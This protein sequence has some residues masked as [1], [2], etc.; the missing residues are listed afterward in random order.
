[1]K[2]LLIVLLLAIPSTVTAET[3]NLQYGDVH[4]NESTGVFA[5]KLD[6]DYSIIVT[7]DWDNQGMSAVIINNETG[8]THCIPRPCNYTN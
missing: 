8:K 5:T 7:T 6:G 4:L 3:I 1:M 2:K